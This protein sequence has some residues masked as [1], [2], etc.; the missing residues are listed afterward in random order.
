MNEKLNGSVT[1]ETALV[2]PIILFLVMAMIELTF[3]LHDRILLK[4]CAYQSCMEKVFDD[5][6]LHL[7]AKERIQ[8]LNLLTIVPSSTWTQGN[9]DEKVTY[10]GDF[11]TPFVVLSSFLPSEKIKEEKSVCGKMNI[12]TMFLTKIITDLWKEEN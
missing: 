4:L 11:S 7:A 3:Y 12:E 9:K 2:M 5:K 8:Q 6:S 10:M 1:L